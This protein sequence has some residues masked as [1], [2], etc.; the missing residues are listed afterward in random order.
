MRPATQEEEEF[1][2]ME[3]CMEEMLV[4]ILV[5]CKLDEDNCRPPWPDV[6]EEAEV[7]VAQDCANA[8]WEGSGYFKPDESALQPGTAGTDSSTKDDINS[9]FVI[10]MPP[11][12]VT[13]ALHMGHAMFVTLED[14]MARFWR[15]K[16][17]PT[18]WLP[19]TDHAGIATQLVVEKMLASEGIS[20][21]QLGREEFVKRV[22]EWKEK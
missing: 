2:E 4:D 8:L 12:N 7:R 10:S 16:G 5:E 19:G 15:M 9:A 11:P 3:E 18:L 20:R 17:R 21:Q 13:G 1:L 22:W 14:I 6:T